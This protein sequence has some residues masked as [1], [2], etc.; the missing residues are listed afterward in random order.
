[1]KHL[2]LIRHAKSSR[3]DEDLD[4]HERPLSN[5]GLS[6]LA[7]LAKALVH[8]GALEGDIFCSDARRTQETLKGAAPELREQ[9]HIRPELYTF[10][11]RNLIRWLK[12]LDDSDSERITLVGHNPALL[13]LAGWLLKHPP[14]HLPTAGFI[15]IRLPITS[16]GQLAKGTGKLEHFLTPRDYSYSHFASGLNK[17]PGGK[18]P[19]KIPEALLYQYQLM[20]QLEPGVILGLD[21]EFTHQYRV[22]IRRSR[23]IAEA[24]RDVT[25]SRLLD[26]PVRQLKQNAGATSRLRDLHVFLQDL[27]RLCNRAPV[28]RSTLEDYFGLAARAEHKRLCRRLTGKR[29]QH[30]MEEWHDLIDSGKFRKLA[31][32]LTSRHIRKSVQERIARFNKRTAALDESSPDQDL[33]WLRK[34]L[35]RIRYLMELDGATWKT[36]LGDLKQR[37]E[38]YGQFQDL[39]VQMELIREFRSSDATG[40]PRSLDTLEHRLEQRKAGIREQILALG[41]LSQKSAPASD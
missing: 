13:E 41:T 40:I 33:H 24:V 27:P 34:Q 38:I 36:A 14:A 7:P 22:A 16:W 18:S 39:H 3:A 20:R 10:D 19:R 31:G 15:H 25:G 8:T 1:M 29:Y 2:F 21:D 32:N 37:Q 28:L 6:Q 12:A 26:R 17:P 35:K 9:L 4:D 5:R 23:A 11:Y 30:S